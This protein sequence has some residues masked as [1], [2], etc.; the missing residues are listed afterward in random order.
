MLT[1]GSSENPFCIDRRWC[2]T[3]Q[4]SYDE[5]LLSAESDNRKRVYNCRH[6]RGRRISENL[7]GILANRWRIYHTVM[8]LEPTAVESV[9]LAILAL[10]NMLMTSSA[11]N[12]YCPAGLCGTEDINRELT[13]GLFRN[14][15]YADSMFSLKKTD[16]ESQRIYRCQRNS[17]YLRWVFYE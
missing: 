10:H 14:D 9:I 17:R 1:Q 2:I 12:I 16:K 8:L 13:L 15:N 6:S 7:L 4:N 5:A 11:K 3:A